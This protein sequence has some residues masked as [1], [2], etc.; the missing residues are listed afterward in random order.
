MPLTFGDSGQPRIVKWRHELAP[1]IA[2][3]GLAAD[4]LSPAALWTILLPF[5]CVVLLMA[6]RKWTAAAAVFL[7]SSWFLIPAA[8]ITVDAIEESRGEHRLFALPGCLGPVLDKASSDAC[9]AGSVDVTVLPIGAGYL[10][11]PRWILR[12][13]IET[14]IALHNAIVIDRARATGLCPAS[15]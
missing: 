5:G 9:A 3:A 8:V 11:N 15:D 12:E 7:L 4:Y 13:N 2:V 1:V 6:L 14:F 10:F